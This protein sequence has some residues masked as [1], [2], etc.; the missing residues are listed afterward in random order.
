M[1]ENLKPR[2][3][4]HDVEGLILAILSKMLDPDNPVFKISIAPYCFTI[5]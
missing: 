3:V 1:L 5:C 2:F 4:A